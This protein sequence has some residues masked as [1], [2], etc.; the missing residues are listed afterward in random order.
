MTSFSNILCFFLWYSDADCMK[1]FHAVSLS[2][3]A[4]LGI[5]LFDDTC[6][7]QLNPITAA[8]ILRE[9]SDPQRVKWYF[10]LPTVPDQPCTR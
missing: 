7:K 1:L 9:L 3:A 4:R 6:M 10:H 5:W 2:Q 8:D